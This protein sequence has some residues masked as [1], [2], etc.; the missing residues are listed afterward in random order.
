MIT[1]ASLYRR[2]MVS[3]SLGTCIKGKELISRSFHLEGDIQLLLPFRTFQTQDLWPQKSILNISSRGTWNESFRCSVEGSA[4][5]QII[6]VAPHLGTNV[7]DHGNER[8]ESRTAYLSEEN[9]ELD[10]LLMNILW[11]KL[12]IVFPRCLHSFTISRC[13]GRLQIDPTAQKMIPHP[14]HIRGGESFEVGNQHICCYQ[15]EQFEPMAAT[16]G[17]STITVGPANAVKVKLEECRHLIVLVLHD[18]HYSLCP[19]VTF[20]SYSRFGTSMNCQ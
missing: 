7:K 18:L 4:H 5:F 1:P 2:E 20:K 14:I 9:F 12:R 6:I 10:Y 16:N 19:I 8:M 3:R 17:T 13:L 11:S 15:G